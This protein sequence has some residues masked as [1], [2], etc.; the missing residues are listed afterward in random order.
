MQAEKLEIL[1]SRKAERAELKAQI[2][3]HLPAAIETR[4]LAITPDIWPGSNEDGRK[5]SKARIMAADEILPG[6]AESLRTNKA[7]LLAVD[8]E[9]E[10]LEDERRE[11]ER[12]GRSML[13]YALYT[14]NVRIENGAPLDVASFSAAAS[15]KAEEL[16]GQRAQA[17]LNRPVTYPQA[18]PPKRV[19]RNNPPEPEIPF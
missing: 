4:T 10:S 9:I 8:A 17:Q 6:L 14:A 2:E 15:T 3:I 7:R 5:L 12:Q 1:R 11:E 13:A 18:Q 16:V 19:I